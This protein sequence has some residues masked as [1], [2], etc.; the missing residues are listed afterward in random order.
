MQI[1]FALVSF[2]LGAVSVFTAELQLLND[3]LAPIRDLAGDVQN[4]L[5]P[6]LPAG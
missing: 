4:V 3:T 2:L 6:I 5:A 1:L